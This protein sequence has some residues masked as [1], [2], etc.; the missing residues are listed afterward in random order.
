MIDSPHLPRV[1]RI[2]ITVIEKVTFDEE[3]VQHIQSIN[4][5]LIEKLCFNLVGLPFSGVSLQFQGAPPFTATASATVMA[6]G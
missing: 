4:Q 5:M 1:Q 6:R 2:E 3:K